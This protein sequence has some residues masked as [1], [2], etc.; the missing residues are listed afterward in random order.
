MKNN[1]NLASRVRHGVLKYSRL[2]FAHR[3]LINVIESQNGTTT[4]EQLRK[5]HNDKGPAKTR[6]LLNEREQER[7]QFR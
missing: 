6:I 2:F 5:H 1:N 3:K 7:L 4:K